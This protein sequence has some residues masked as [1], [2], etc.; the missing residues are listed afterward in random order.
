M[1]DLHVHTS[2]FSDGEMTLAEVLERA[3]ELGVRVGIADHW[4]HGMNTAAELERYLDTLDRYPV[5]K[6]LEV[7]LGYPF[8]VPDELVSRLD[9]I[10]GSLHDLEWRGARHSF[11]LGDYFLYTLGEKPDYAGPSPIW[12]PATLERALEVYLRAMD[13]QPISILGHSTLLPP[14]FLKDP[15]MALP[16][17]WMERLISAAVAKGVAFELSGAWHVPHRGFVVRALEMGARFAYG[18]DAHRLPMVGDLE[19]P[20]R[21]TRELGIPEERIFR[22]NGAR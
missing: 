15:E 18:S 11:E 13:E 8:I 14:L 22:P 1:L 12:E 3:G 2:D 19:Y 10:I 17:S 4:I 7:S 5:C 6:G 20:L 16:E 9:Y 21:I